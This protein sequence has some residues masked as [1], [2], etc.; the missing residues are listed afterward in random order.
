[1]SFANGKGVLVQDICNDSGVD[2]QLVQDADA[3]VS[4]MDAD[5]L[6]ASAFRL[7]GEPSMPI[8]VG[9]RLG[10]RSCNLLQHLM[11]VSPDL[12]SATRQ[13]QKFHRL[14]TDEQPPMLS[15]DS[16]AQQATMEYFFESSGCLEGSQ[17]RIL[18]SMTGHLYWLRIKCGKHFTPLRMELTIDEARMGRAQLEYSLGC[19]VQFN[20]ARNAIVFDERNLYVES[21]FHNQHL[22]ALMEKQCE[23][24]TQRLGSQQH[25]VANALRSALQ[26]GALDYRANIEQAADFIGVSTRTLNRYLKSEGT[27]YKTLLSEERIALAS[28][29]LREGERCIEDVAF[30]VGYSSRRSFDRAFTQA[31][32]ISPAVARKQPL[33]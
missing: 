21:P 29:L 5:K 27:N 11:I 24:L 13:Q 2:S 12:A 10:T 9:Y 30:D 4:I 3:R 23:V 1:M 19:P 16:A 8:K 15:I 18:I 31:V 6:V 20:A 7:T 17:Q 33:T 28:R 14:F 26:N 32:G 25:Y 22:L